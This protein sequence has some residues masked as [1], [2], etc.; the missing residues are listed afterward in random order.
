MNKTEQNTPDSPAVGIPVDWRVGPVARVRYMTAGGNAG[1]AWRAVS[2]PDCD[3]SMPVEGDG[4]YD[5]SAVFIAV[6][7]TIAAERV[8]YMQEIERLRAA[9]RWQD[10]RDGR[11][12]THGPGCHAWG[13]S[14]YECAIR[15]IS[16]AP[17]AI[18]DTRTE[19]GLCAPTEAD[20]PALYALQGRRVA[21]V[22]LG[23][24]AGK[25]DTSAPGLT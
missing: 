23:P 19:L 10:A 15:L 5:S 13:P 20:F 14:H 12:G 21:L 2:E 17:V 7:H 24:S 1:I 8:W 18:M 3:G 9:L 11:I 22:D 25:P 4:L 6:Q 16:A